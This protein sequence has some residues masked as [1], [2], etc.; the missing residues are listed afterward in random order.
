M[1]RSIYNLVRLARPGH[2]IKNLF[3]LAALVFSRGGRDARL[4]P[5]VCDL[6]A[7]VGAALVAFAAFCLASSAVYALNDVLDR[8]E[9]ARHPTKR[10]RPVASGET[11]PAAAAVLAAVLAAGG[12]AAAWAVGARVLEVLALYLAVMLGYVAG[13]KRVAVLDVILLAV[14]FVLRAYAGGVAI[15]VWISPWLILCTLTLALFLGFAKRESERVALGAAAGETRPVEWELYDEKS[16]EHMMTVSAA[17][18]IV[19]YMLYTVSSETI[20]RVGHSWM[21]LT[22]LPVVYGVFRFYRAAIAGRAGD[23]VDLVRR[24]PAFVAAVAAWAGMAAALLFV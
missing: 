5:E 6:A 12:L 9:D 14:G 7:A 21:C 15:G 8:R 18:A 23:P 1:M 24:D 11:S 3:V 16:L 2:W 4:G 13:L 22:V 19:T 17:L 20:H 10:R